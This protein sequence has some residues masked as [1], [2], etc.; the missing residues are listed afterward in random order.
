MRVILITY[1]VCAN[2]LLAF[3]NYYQKI[4]LQNKSLLWQQHMR[5]FY[6][7]H[8]NVLLLVLVSV[9]SVVILVV[10]SLSAYTLLLPV[11]V[12]SHRLC[13]FFELS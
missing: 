3:L 4:K 6:Q 11:C 7:R 5:S 13:N 1:A 12:C 9:V 8:G 10:V 2:Y